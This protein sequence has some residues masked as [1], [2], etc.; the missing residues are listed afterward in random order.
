[1]IL[2]RRRG[3]AHWI[4]IDDPK[5]KNAIDREATLPSKDALP[6]LAP[7]AVRSRQLWF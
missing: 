2:S 7:D 1:V 6:P 4:T 3:R 5:S